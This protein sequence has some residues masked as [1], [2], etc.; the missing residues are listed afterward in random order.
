MVVVRMDNEDLDP[1][2]IPKPPSHNTAPNQTSTV[3]RPLFRW[4]MV[5]LALFACGLLVALFVLVVVR[6]QASDNRSSV[7]CQNFLSGTPHA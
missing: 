1:E 4:I 3:S 2:E 5:G 6:P 7:K